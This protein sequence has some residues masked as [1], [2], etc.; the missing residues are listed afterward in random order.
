MA[1]EKPLLQPQD[2]HIVAIATDALMDAA[3]PLIHLDDIP[4]VG[5]M[6]LSKAVALDELRMALSADH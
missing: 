3:V 5:A 2:P 1:N 4:A 6:M